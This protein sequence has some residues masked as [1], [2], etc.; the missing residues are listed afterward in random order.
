MLKTIKIKHNLPFANVT[1]HPKVLE[2]K[3]KEVI[4]KIDKEFS[5][6]LEFLSGI[7]DDECK[8]IGSEDNV[9]KARDYFI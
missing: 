4:K 5:V 1:L 6:K 3:Q 9:R 8:L 7:F 2:K